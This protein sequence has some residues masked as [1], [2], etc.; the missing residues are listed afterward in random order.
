SRPSQACCRSFCSRDSEAYDYYATM[1]AL[2]LLCQIAGFGWLQTSIIRLYV[3]QHDQDGRE[4]FTQAVRLGFALSA[5]FVCI[6]W[7]IGLLARAGSCDEMLLGIGGLAVL[8]SGSWA[9]NVRSW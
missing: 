4:R 2:T 6:A 5:A 1:L 9:E 3:E 8:L 7:T